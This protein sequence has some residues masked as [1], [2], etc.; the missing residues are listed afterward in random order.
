MQLTKDQV[1]KLQLLYKKH[2]AVDLSQDE[3]AEKGMQLVR[4]MQ[5]AYK[6][7]PKGGA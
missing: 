4:M 7:I 3:A 5:Q 6:P 1:R 2:F